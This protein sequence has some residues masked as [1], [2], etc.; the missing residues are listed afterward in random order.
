MR[1]KINKMLR[2][3][4]KRETSILWLT[5][6]VVIF[7]IGFNFLSETVL[8]K[9]DALNKEISITRVKLKKYLW[10]LAHKDSIQNKYKQFASLTDLA[11]EIKKDTL[12][13]VLS[14]L[15]TIARGSNI[16]ILD[17]RPQS[18]KDPSSYREA[19]VD[20]KTEGTLQDYLKFI[21]NIENSL[22]LLRIK[23][24]QLNAKP[25][26]QNLEGSFSISRSTFL[27]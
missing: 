8:N 12:V 25:N 2:I 4:T 24:L 14:E 11:K 18:Q 20:L 21:Y 23:R 1:E 6:A 17:L 22:S 10:L 9:N 16:R 5:V 7:A 3:L 13:D 15:E 19:L 26:T 27:D